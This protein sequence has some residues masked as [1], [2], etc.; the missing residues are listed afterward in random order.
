MFPFADS[1]TGETLMSVR[2]IDLYH[3]A[4]PLKKTIRHAS[5]ERVVSDNL[6]VRR[7]WMT[8]EPAIGEGV[9][10][11]LCHRRDDR[12]HFRSPEPV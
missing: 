1:P 3:V 10:R 5:H 8:V 9:P 4:V 6:V 11:D 12:H 7:T 2:S